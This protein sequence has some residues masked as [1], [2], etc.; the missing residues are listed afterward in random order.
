MRSL[1]EASN[2][3]LKSKNFEDLGN[4]DKRS[5]RG[6]AF[7]YLLATFMGV[8]SNLRRIVAF[9]IEEATRL[10]QGPL[11]REHRRKETTGKALA[12]PESLL[13]APPL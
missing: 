6:Y 7:Q 8:S 13:P 1:V 9:F 5:G 4:P 12:K 2:N 11:P 3:H 10:H